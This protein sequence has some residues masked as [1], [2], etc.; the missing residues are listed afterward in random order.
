M[1]WA[2]ITTPPRSENKAMR[3]LSQQG[4]TSYAPV[5]KSTRKVSGRRVEVI[6]FLFPR[7]LFLWVVDQ[8]RSVLGTIGVSSVILS[9]HQPARIPPQWVDGMKSREVDGFVVLPQERYRRGERVRISRGVLEG[10]WGIY[11]GM[12]TK[13][14][15][16]VLLS[17]L[18]RVELAAGM[19][20]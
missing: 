10:H 15:E 11:Q 9:N 20:D 7:Y 3:H 2:V 13:Q 16:V 6:D 17:V 14:R 5:C 8:W 18:G 1:Y 12:N 19:L 4:F